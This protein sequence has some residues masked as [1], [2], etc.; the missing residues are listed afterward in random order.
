M[1]RDS[2]AAV[3]AE[4]GWADAVRNTA[5]VICSLNIDAAALD[6]GCSAGI[7]TWIA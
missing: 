3:R 6:A 1:V 5:Q 2:R 4:G 7:L